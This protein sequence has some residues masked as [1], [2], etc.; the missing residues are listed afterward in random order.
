M[1]IKTI[2]LFRHGESD[3]NFDF[4]KDHARSLTKKGIKATEKMGAY[5]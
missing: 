2:I 4:D 1:N 5:L 3:W